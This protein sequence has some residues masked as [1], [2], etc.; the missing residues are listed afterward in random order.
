MRKKL[1]CIFLIDDDSEDNH[2]H[3]IVIRDM[4]ITSTIEIAQNGLEALALLTKPNHVAPELIFLDINMP[5]MNGWE[6]LEAYQKLASVQKA[7]VIVVMLSTSINPSDKKRATQFVEITSF[8]SKPLTEEIINEI[9]RKN[10][11]EY[12]ELPT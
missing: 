8:N 12:I 7:K 2:F 4:N 3:Q 11:P 9:L 10:F 6:F 5:K 1:N